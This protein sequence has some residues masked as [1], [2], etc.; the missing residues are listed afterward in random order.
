MFRMALCFVQSQTAR[1]RINV[2]A[3]WLCRFLLNVTRSLKSW[4][5]C[6][7]NLQS[8][9][10]S[11]VPM[12]L[13]CLPVALQPWKRKCCHVS[14]KCLWTDSSMSLGVLATLNA[15]EGRGSARQMTSRLLRLCW[16]IWICSIFVSML[17]SNITIGMTRIWSL[18]PVWMFHTSVFWLSYYGHFTGVLQYFMFR[19]ASTCTIIILRL[20]CRRQTWGWDYLPW[21]VIH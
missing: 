15:G 16:K 4:I 21:G 11:T 14:I 10:S 12:N 1:W 17:M 3:K 13:R 5:R 9:V 6:W 8:D 7:H 18:W 19:T 2:C 20:P